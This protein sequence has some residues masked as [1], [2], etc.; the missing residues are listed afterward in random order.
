MRQDP[1]ENRKERRV[2]TLWPAQTMKDPGRLQWLEQIPY[3][4]PI[5]NNKMFDIL[6]A[7]MTV[8]DTP[9]EESDGHPTT[10]LDSHANMPVVG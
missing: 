10:E 6:T 4:Q 7:A 5:Y 8:S 9:V 2:S 1:S 3:L